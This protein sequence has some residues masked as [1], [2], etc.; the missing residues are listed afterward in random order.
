MGM[1]TRTDYNR[2]DGYGD[3]GGPRSRQRQRQQGRGW[4]G[5]R[6][7]STPRRANTTN[8][9]TLSAMDNVQPIPSV[10]DDIN[11]QQYHPKRRRPPAPLQTAAPPHTIPSCT[12]ARTPSLTHAL[13]PHTPTTHLPACIPSRP[14]IHPYSCP[15]TRTPSP[16]P[17]RQPQ[18]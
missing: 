9:L 6:E 10:I 17:S 7:V 18:R 5:S 12:L 16:I 1:K 4:S 8:I 2:K 13:P 14:H 11:A 3:E 15:H